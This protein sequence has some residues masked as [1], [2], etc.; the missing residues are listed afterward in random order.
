MASKEGTWDT[1]LGY[2]YWKES[3]NKKRKHCLGEKSLVGVLTFTFKFI[4]PNLLFR[5]SRPR[6]VREQTVTSLRSNNWYQSLRCSK[7]VIFERENVCIQE[8]Q[9]EGV[10]LE[11]SVGPYRRHKQYSHVPKIMRSGITDYV[12]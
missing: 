3:S 12:L 7:V 2:L 1:T 8:Q 9:R 4:I 10:F 6:D 11:V 5:L